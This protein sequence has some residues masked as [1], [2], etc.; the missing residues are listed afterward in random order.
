MIHNE[1]LDQMYL[2]YVESLIHFKCYSV[3][4]SKPFFFSFF[5]V[6]DYNNNN[7]IMPKKEKEKKLGNTLGCYLF[8]TKVWISHLC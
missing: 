4:F 6:P 1:Y 5:I 3:E 7:L 2:L 8:Q